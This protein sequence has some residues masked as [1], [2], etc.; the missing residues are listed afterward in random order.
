MY[1]IVIIGAGAGGGT[2]AYALK[3]SGLKILIIE[4]GDFIDQEEENESIDAAYGG[5]RYGTSEQWKNIY[6]NTTLTDFGNIYCV[7][8]RTKIYGSAL[9]RFRK[10]DFEVIHHQDGISPAWPISYNAFEPYYSQ[11]EKLYSVHGCSKSEPCA[12]PRSTPYAYPHLPYDSYIQKL[13]S[14]FKMQGLNP[15]PIP[16]GIISEKRQ[17]INGKKFDGYPSKTHAKAETDICCIRPALASK[18][19]SLL[20]NAT[21]N[22]LIPD[23]T[24]TRVEAIEITHEGVTKTIR[25]K[26]FVLSCGSIHS[27]A[28]LL[29]SHLANSSGL[30][31]KNLMMHTSSAIIC[32]HPHKKNHSEFQKSFQIMDYY[33]KGKNGWP[34]GCIQTL[35]PFPFAAFLP[36]KFKAMGEF[37][38]DRSMQ[39]VAITEDLPDPNNSVSLDASGK[40]VIHYKTNNWKTQKKLRK[41]A[42]KILKKAIPLSIVFP[43]ASHGKNLSVSHSCGTLVF[44][45]D[46][47]TSV[48]DLYCKAH[49]LD[50]LYVVDSSFFPSSGAINPALTIMAQ[51]LRVGEHL[52]KLAY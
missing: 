30:V 41:E 10:E 40:I 31:G 47:K 20:T 16:L 7:G 50:N 46:P 35:G 9:I 22:R 39:L 34:W 37:F 48:L 13:V 42:C 4:K 45:N 33:L 12:P 11:A 15:S 2:L 51:A 25:A 36:K 29:K 8:G 43:I 28:L 17:T 44:G 32:F 18:G 38:T 14:H 6:N 49:D 24:G 3:D 19:I 5:K 21:A 26:R 27:P 1:D 23:A 52:C